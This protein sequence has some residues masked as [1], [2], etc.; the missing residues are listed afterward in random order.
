MNKDKD[1]VVQTHNAHN[2]L[3]NCF[4]TFSFKEVEPGAQTDIGIIRFF[5]FKKKRYC[6]FH[7]LEVSEV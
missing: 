4:G 5:F 7:C 2:L 1:W 3:C 6:V